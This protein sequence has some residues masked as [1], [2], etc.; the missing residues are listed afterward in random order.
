MIIII[1]HKID[2]SNPNYILLLINVCIK[3]NFFQVGSLPRRAQQD[4]VDSVD[5]I[6]R[7]R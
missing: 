2:N 4:V 1:C 6:P 7:T 5:V 3:Y